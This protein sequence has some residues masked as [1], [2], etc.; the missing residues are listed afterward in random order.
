MTR[1]QLKIQISDSGLTFWF[2][3][4][5]KVWMRV[6]AY[7]RL[8]QEFSSTAALREKTGSL[9]RELDRTYNPENRGLDIH[10]EGP[11]EAA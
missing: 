3:N 1:N 9:L 6:S 2:Q 10:L 8:A 7:S 11:K 4:E 5:Q